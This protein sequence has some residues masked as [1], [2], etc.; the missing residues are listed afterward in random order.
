M[1][2]LV[3]YTRAQELQSEGF[4]QAFNQLVTCRGLA[5]LDLGDVCYLELEGRKNGQRRIRISVGA[6]T[7][8]EDPGVKEISVA[9]YFPDSVDA[10]QVAVDNIREYGSDEDLSICVLSPISYMHQ[11]NLMVEEPDNF[12]MPPGALQA[13][14]LSWLYGEQVNQIMGSRG[15]YIGQAHI[16]AGITGVPPEEAELFMELLDQ[17]KVPHTYR[18]GHL[19]VS[20]RLASRVTHVEELVQTYLWAHERDW[21]VE[22]VATGSRKE[23]RVVVSHD[24]DEVCVAAFFD[25]PNTL[26]RNQPRELQPA[27][28]RRAVDFAQKNYDG[29]LRELQW[30]VRRHVN[31]GRYCKRAE[32]NYF[33]EY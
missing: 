9:H 16:F 11:Y 33:F 30:S 6:K 22:Q 27:V 18:E 14:P 32:R 28:V 13:R 8:F 21:H 5:D 3:P 4:V 15:G 19:A 12:L 7:V 17:M 20:H 26:L 25:K 29:H 24:D 1:T 2:T 10:R 23:G 31:S